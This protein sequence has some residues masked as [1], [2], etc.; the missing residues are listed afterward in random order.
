MWLVLVFFCNAAWPQRIRS[1]ICQANPAA[2]SGSFAIQISLLSHKRMFCNT[3]HSLIHHLR[4][5]FFA[6]VETYT[7][8]EHSVGWGSRVHAVWNPEDALYGPGMRSLTVV[9]SLHSHISKDPYWLSSTDEILAVKKFSLSSQ[10][11]TK[12]VATLLR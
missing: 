3:N 12:L 5:I 4:S 9:N 6:S 2:Y 10:C 1:R 11:L 7:A 8:L